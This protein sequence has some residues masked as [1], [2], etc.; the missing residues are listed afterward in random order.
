MLVNRMDVCSSFV[1]Q[2]PNAV[3]V[4]S[5]VATQSGVAALCAVSQT[6]FLNKRYF[7]MYVCISRDNVTIYS[8]INLPGKTE[9]WAADLIEME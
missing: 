7:N 8:I 6:F 5:G 2:C 1:I 9:K 3:F 4:N